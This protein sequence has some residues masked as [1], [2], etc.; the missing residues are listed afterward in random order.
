[1]QTITRAVVGQKLLDYLN[2]ELTLAQIV[3]WAEG[4]FIDGQLLPDADMDMLND[5]LSYLA[6]ADSWQFP[7][8]WDICAGFLERLGL[9]VHVV[10][11]PAN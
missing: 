4:T 2:H 3:D 11:Q 5:I 1:M 8:T 7:L 10:A 9:R 6:A